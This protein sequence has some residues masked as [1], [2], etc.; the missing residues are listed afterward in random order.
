MV[1]WQDELAGWAGWR[2]FG[3]GLVAGRAGWL[4]WV[5]AGVR[6]SEAGALVAVMAAK[7]QWWSLGTPSRL[8]LAGLELESAVRL[9]LCAVMCTWHTSLGWCLAGWVGVRQAELCGDG[10]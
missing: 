1:S 6:W 8:R 2:L 9:G 5:E 10:G 7:D 4:G 3:S